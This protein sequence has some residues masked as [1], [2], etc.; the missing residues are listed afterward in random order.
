MVESRAKA[1]VGRRKRARWLGFTLTETVVA[2]GI[3]SVALSGFYVSV[4][5]GLRIVKLATEQGAASQLLEQRFEELRARP[6]WR[7]VITISGIK[8]ALAE[9]VAGASILAQASETCTVG[10]YPGE[11]IAFS[12]TRQPDGTLSAT[13]GSLPGSQTSV[14]VVSSVSWGAPPQPRRTRSVA[15]VFTKGGL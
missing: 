10:P 15:T 6:M 8:A 4:A 11:A 14:R 2:M 13:G 9:E 5:Q 3:C 7:N 1:I 12:V